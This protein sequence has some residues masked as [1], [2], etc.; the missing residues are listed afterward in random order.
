M[1]NWL[2]RPWFQRL[3]LLLAIGVACVGCSSVPSFSEAI[4]PNPWE[5]VE[6]PT[7]KTPLALDFVDRDRGWL[8]GKGGSILSTADGGR[9]WER[10]PL[11]LGEGNLNLTGVSFA[12]D[13][14]WIVGKPALLLHT[15]DGG[16]TWSDIPLSSKLPGDP[17]LITALGPSQA[18][19][20]TDLGA[21]YRTEDG[22][23][24]WKALVQESVGVL[25]NLSRSAD[26]R[27]VAVSARGNFYSTW[28]PGQAAWVQHNRTSSKRLHNMGFGPDGRLW[29]ILQGGLVQFSEAADDPES[30]QDARAPELASSLGFLDLAY[31]DGGEIWL[32]G[33]SANL[34]YSSDGGETWYKDRE[35]ENLP[36]NFYRVAFVAPD[37]GFVLGQGNQIL[38][39]SGTPAAA[40]A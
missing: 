38:R 9:T 14:G 26:G 4:G 13:E 6:L 3:A 29:A 5:I 40:P 27:Y 1:L 39:Y 21:I 23:R 34:L 33:G 20:A 15:E 19:M 11:D 28:D 2:P 7:D 17:A 16:Q 24:N 8:V 10:K 35:V 31:R 36:T 12:G 18:E 25:R 37:L 30:L 22:G 32:A